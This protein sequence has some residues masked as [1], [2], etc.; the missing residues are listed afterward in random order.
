MM[1][2]LNDGYKHK[3]DPGWYLSIMP[4]RHAKHQECI[5]IKFTTFCISAT[6]TLQ[7][8]LLASGSHHNSNEEI[9]HNT[10]WNRWWVGPNNS[11]DF[12]T[13]NPSPVGNCTMNI[14]PTVNNSLSGQFQLVN[15]YTRRQFLTWFL[16][17]WDFSKQQIYITGTCVIVNETNLVYNILSIFHQIHL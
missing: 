17:L 6:G 7:V 5:E 13:N 4:Q 12:M 14:N 3:G 1:K 9:P 11:L 8:E 15:L 16:F 10:W 2:M